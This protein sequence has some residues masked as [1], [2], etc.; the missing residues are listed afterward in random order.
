VWGYD[1]E[2]LTIILDDKVKER[3]TVDTLKEFIEGF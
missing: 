2:E 3:Y 1:G